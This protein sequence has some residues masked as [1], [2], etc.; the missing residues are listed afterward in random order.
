MELVT[1]KSSKDFGSLSIAKTFLESN[2]IV[3]VF[4]DEYMSQLYAQTDVV[5]GT[6][7]QVAEQDAERAIELLIEGGFATKAD[8]EIPQSTLRTVRIVEKILSFFKRKK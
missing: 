7:L 2:G 5:G 6:K 3:V 1:V 8:Y 4:K